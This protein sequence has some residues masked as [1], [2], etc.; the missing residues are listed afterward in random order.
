MIVQPGNVTFTTTIP[1]VAMRYSPTDLLAVR[2]SMTEG[3]VTPG[4]YELFGE[5][6]QSI[7]A[8]NV[9]TVRWCE[10]GSRSGIRR[11]ITF[12]TSVEAKTDDH[13]GWSFSAVSTDVEIT[14]IWT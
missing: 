5:P 8:L 1:K 2:A 12:A 14:A 4:L 13:L 6:G 3:F 9:N 10:L 11:G 7:S